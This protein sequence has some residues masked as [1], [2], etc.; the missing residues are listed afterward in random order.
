MTNSYLENVEIEFAYL[1]GQ[2]QP[3]VQT[4]LDTIDNS[5]WDSLYVPIN[6]FES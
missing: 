3:W 1:Y 4:T 6:T 2:I 5:I